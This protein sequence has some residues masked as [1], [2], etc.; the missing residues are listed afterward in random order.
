MT[1]VAG[2]YFGNAE[3]KRV[4]QGTTVAIAKGALLMVDTSNGGFIL[5]TAATTAF[6]PYAVAVSATATGSTM[7]NACVGGLVCVQTTKDTKP[8]LLLQPSI[9]TAGRVQP[10]TA[11][12][13]NLTTD[14]TEF[15]R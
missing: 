5:A 14:A 1:L 2:D 6:G 4:K 11:R 7:V 13:I 8:N 15:K 10:Y 12:T 3:V 9:S